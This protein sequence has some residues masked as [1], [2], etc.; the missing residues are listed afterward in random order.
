MPGEG[1]ISFGLK[2]IDQKTFE[3][4]TQKDDVQP[5]DPDPENNLNPNAGPDGYPIAVQVPNKAGFVFSPYNNQV[6]DVRG[7]PSGTL[8]MDPHFPAAEKKYFRIP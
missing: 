4:R 5:D 6:V 1:K 2:R 3:E 7:L 8:V